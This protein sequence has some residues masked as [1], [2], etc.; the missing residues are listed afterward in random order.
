MKGSRF[1]T[2]QRQFDPPSLAACIGT[3]TYD[4]KK[5]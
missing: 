4:I 1:R 5:S 2:L 3:V